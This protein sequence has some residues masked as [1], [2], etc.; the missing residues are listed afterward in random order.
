MKYNIAVKIEARAN[1]EVE[2]SSF[3]EAFELG[4]EAVVYV[5]RPEW[6][7]IEPVSAERADG[8]AADYNILPY[9]D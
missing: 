8:R 9:R 2:A 3:E 5:D 7:D 1:V 6:I 4:K